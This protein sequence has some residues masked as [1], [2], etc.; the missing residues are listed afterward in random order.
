MAKSNEP[1]S[2]SNFNQGGLSDSRWSG[3]ASSFYKLTGLDMHSTPGLLKVAQKLTKV[4]GSTVTAFCRSSVVS[5]NG[6]V[7][8]FSYTDGKIWQQT[9]SDDTFTLIYTTSP[10]AGA[11]GCLGAFEYQGYIYWAT[12]SRLHRIVA[13][14]NDTAGEWTSNVA[15][16]WATFTNTDDLF[17][18]M[19]ELNQVLYIGDGKYVA[20]VD[21]GT[22]TANAL[23]IK[24][25]LRVKS[26]GK[27]NVDLLVG[28]WVSDVITQTELLRWNTYSVSYTTSDTIPETG[29]NAFIPADNFVLVQ[30]GAAG[31]IYTYNGETL[32][33]YKTIPGEYTP[34]KYGYVHPDSVANFHGQML[35]GMSNG[36]G[37]PCDMG[38]YRL[39]R[40]D[41]KY[42]FILDFPY[43]I[44][45][46][47]EGALVTSSI[48]IGAITVAGFNVYV[49]WKNDTTYGVDK[50]DYTTKLNGAYFETRVMAIA[51]EK[52]STMDDFNLNYQAI[53]ASCA[54]VLSYDKNY[55]GYVAM[56]SI[57]D[58]DRLTVSAQ[59]G[60][61]ASTLSVKVAFTTNSND[62]P[63][64]ESGFVSL[65]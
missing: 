10:A 21:A 36:S 58:T 48:E 18:P 8:H 64:V 5:S 15:A 59:E 3:T 54:L 17:H 12:Q 46:R 55:A 24:S 42:P 37:N 9:I 30:A 34:T 19:Y 23:D 28:T 6:F 65:K 16:N 32:E 51:R 1:I 13:A 60:V 25:P 52:L 45:E 38:V 63:T 61:E 7:Y 14:G 29:I 56:A 22:F 43:P 2:I 35:F 62:G 31:N 11:A 47:S 57:K 53:P 33:L 44:S 41:K 50:I 27:M 26:L 39:A 20:Q 40:H 49:A 4:S